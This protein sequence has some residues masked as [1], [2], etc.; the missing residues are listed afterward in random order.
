MQTIIVMTRGLLNLIVTFRRARFRELKKYLSF[1]FHLYIMHRPPS[2]KKRLI[3]GDD[4]SDFYE[5]DIH[6][7]Q[8]DRK[9]SF[10]PTQDTTVSTITPAPQETATPPPQETPILTSSF[11]DSSAATPPP[12]D[13]STTQSTLK[14][15]PTTS[16]VPEPLEESD[17]GN[18][19]KNQPRLVMK[20]MVLNDFK[21][22][23]GR[24]VI[25]PFHKV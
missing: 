5:S 8:P 15:N 2:K 22:Y 10:K 13:S 4:D 18:I 3:K 1:F 16:T 21:S 20:K 11:N 24:Q 6:N 25:G 17:E 23:A 9:V 19:K 14:E 7:A 12:I